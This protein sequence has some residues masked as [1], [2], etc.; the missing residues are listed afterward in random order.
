M[1]LYYN[2]KT[3]SK[4]NDRKKRL[5]FNHGKFQHQSQVESRDMSELDSSWKQNGAKT[6]RRWGFHLPVPVI[7]YLVNNSEWPFQPMFASY[8]PCKEW[9]FVFA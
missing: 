2:R 8:I 5:T 6:D 4:T 1:G 7:D 9:K 3:L